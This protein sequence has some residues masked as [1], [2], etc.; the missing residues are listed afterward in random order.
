M[1]KENERCGRFSAKNPW[2]ILRT[3]SVADGGTNRGCDRACG[4]LKPVNTA[5]REERCLLKR[6]CVAQSCL[7]GVKNSHDVRQ[8]GVHGVWTR[9][10]SSRCEVVRS[11]V[12]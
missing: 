9:F 6:L 5:T 12:H 10:F 8:T 1:L 4:G 2:G 7:M 3:C 11:G